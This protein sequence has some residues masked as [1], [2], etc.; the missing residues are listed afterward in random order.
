M[1]AR[2]FLLAAAALVTQAFAGTPTIVAPALDGTLP[3]KKAP[4]LSAKRLSGSLTA[5]YASNYTCRGLVA[6]H[7]MVQGD[8]TEYISADLSY[9]IGREGFF[10]I[11]NHTAY[12]VISSGHKLMGVPGVNIEN[13]FVLENSLRY[14]RKYAFASLGHQFTHGG[15]LG[16]QIKHGKGEG[17]SALNEVFVTVGVTPLSWL[18]IG[19]KASYAFDGLKGWWFEPYAKGSWTLIGTGEKPTLEG[20]V[21]A[22]FTAT[23]GNFGEYAVQ[24]DGVQSWWIAAALPWHLT[25]SLVLTPIVSFNWLGEGAQNTGNLFRNHAIV[26]SVNATYIF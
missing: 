20:V 6:S 25:E 8:S 11:E 12:T 10:T 26:A 7:A 21:M 9:D 17:A 4:M 15:L 19:V 18:E 3:C 22:G 5:G 24:S 2:Y 14:T 13:E 1:K 16:S 23:T